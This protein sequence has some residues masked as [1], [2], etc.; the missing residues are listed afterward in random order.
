MKRLAA[1]FVLLAVMAVSAPALA[2]QPDEVLQDPVLEQR[3]RDLSAGLWSKRKSPAT[4]RVAART[5]RVTSAT[6]RSGI[7]AMRAAL[8]SEC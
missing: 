5:S 1:M 8:P 2:V 4:S 6:G 7:S 3:A